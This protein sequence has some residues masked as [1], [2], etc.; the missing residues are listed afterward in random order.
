MASWWQRH[1]GDS[2]AAE[3]WFA[4]ARAAAAAARLLLDQ[5]FLPEAMALAS[6]AILQAGRAALAHAGRV[7][8]NSLAAEFEAVLVRPARLHPRFLEVLHEAEERR[9]LIER[10]PLWLP[11]G[12][13]ARL[14]LAR[15]ASFLNGI[16]A[17]LGHGER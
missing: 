7:Q 11:A 15:T 1:P 3:A 8:V 2:T 4:R 9:D 14:A 6:T 5:G 17:L 12:E 10:D 13:E 16:Q